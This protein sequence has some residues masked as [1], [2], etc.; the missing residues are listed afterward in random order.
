MSDYCIER[1]YIEETDH[2]G[3]VRW[4]KD[5]RYLEEP[6]DHM[7]HRDDVKDV[8]EMYHPF[9]AIITACHDGKL[10]IISTAMKRI[11]GIL[12]AGHSTGIR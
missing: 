4:S 9:M 2:L 10:R 7:G 12:H 8:R 5:N 1:P 3:K 6:F 11:V